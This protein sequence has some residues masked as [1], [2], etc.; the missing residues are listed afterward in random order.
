MYKEIQKIHVRVLE[1]REKCHSQAICICLSSLLSLS[2]KLPSVTHDVDLCIQQFPVWSTAA[3][4]I[5]VSKGDNHY[6]I[7]G[8]VLCILLFRNKLQVPPTVTL[9]DFQYLKILLRWTA[10]NYMMLLVYIV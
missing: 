7:Q 5:N 4:S 6:K 3:Y 2:W 1:N 8:V 9:R 10:V